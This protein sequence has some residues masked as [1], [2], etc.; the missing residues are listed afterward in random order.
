MQTATRRDPQDAEALI[1]LG[2]VLESSEPQEAL[3][4][5]TSAIK[6]IK[7]RHAQG[8]V[9]EGPPATLLNN[10]AVLHLHVGDK[11][12]SRALFAQAVAAAGAS[13]GAL[14]VH[15]AGM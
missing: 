3:A 14:S 13:V 12:A 6:I 1:E 2:E 10:A 9:A 5:Y 7:R 4:A 15:L 11:E 8:L